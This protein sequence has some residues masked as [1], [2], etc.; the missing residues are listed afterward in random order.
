M[1][2][3]IAAGVVF[4]VAFVSGIIVASAWDDPP[5]AF[6]W[7]YFIASGISV[8]VLIIVGIVAGVRALLGLRGTRDSRRQTRESIAAYNKRLWD[9]RTG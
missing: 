4:G 5:M 8:W 9:D 2:I 7:F 6:A 1:R 3:A